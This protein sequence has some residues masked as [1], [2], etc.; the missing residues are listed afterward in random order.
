MEIKNKNED[1]QSSSQVKNDA[2]TVTVPA[3]PKAFGLGGLVPAGGRIKKAA[4]KQVAKI[5]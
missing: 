2:D 3:K 5:I 4:A 1:G